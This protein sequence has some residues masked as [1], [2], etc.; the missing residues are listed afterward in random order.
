[1][2]ETSEF[3]IQSLDK[4]GDLN[5]QNENDDTMMTK[6]RGRESQNSGRYTHSGEKFS[7]MMSNKILC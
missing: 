7:P 5:P 3:S 4:G 6:Y 2:V 1:M